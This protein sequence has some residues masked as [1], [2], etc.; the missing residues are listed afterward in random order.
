MTCNWNLY[1]NAN[2]ISFMQHVPQI[3]EDVRE[4]KEF[5]EKLNK[6]KKE[7]DGRQDKAAKRYYYR[8]VEEVLEKGKKSNYI[9]GDKIR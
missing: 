7:S 1:L 2:E 5:K 3:D 4:A 6:W 9:I 8:S